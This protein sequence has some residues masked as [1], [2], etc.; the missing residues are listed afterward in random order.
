MSATGRLRAALARHN[1]PV[2]SASSAL[3][4]YLF[5]IDGLV[6]VWTAAVLL[7]SGRVTGHAWWVLLLLVALALLFE[8]GASRAARLQLRLSSDLKRDMTSVWA[9][10]GAVALPASAAVL[11][12]G[13]VLV[14]VWF[15][16]QR[17][18]RQPL[19]R[20]WFNGSTC[21]LGCLTAGLT[22]DSVAGTWGGLP[23][24]LAGALSVVCA[25]VV[26][27]SVNRLLVTVALVL[28]G[29][30]GR[31]LAGSRDDNLIEL[32]TLCLGGLVAVTAVHEPWLCL[33]VLAPMVTLQRGAL[34]RELETAAMTDSKTGLLNAVAWE[35]LA[36]REMSRADRDGKPVALL[37]IDIDRFKLVN[38][39]HGHM[40]GDVVLRGVGRCL[41]AEVREYDTVGRFGGEEFVA[42]LPEATEVEA[43]IVAERLRSRVNE[44]CVSAMVEGIEPGEDDAMA[45]SIGVACSPIDGIE[46]SEL[47][48]AADGALYGAKAGGRNRVV[49]ADRGSGDAFE[50]VTHS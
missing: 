7:R 50:R 5:L 10:A 24:A 35:Q 32:A 6:L 18:A 33:L 49:L 4:T 44:L 40:V 46:L 21:V 36:K 25:I 20:V 27:T 22:V 48:V 16:Q 47:L 1:W 30:R 39:R 13:S 26:Y 9:V 37:I 23:W 17:L 45:V 3:L 8:E 31:T 19:Y 28:V 12:L 2:A 42:V 41:D 11:L 14:Y 29:A 38:D 34:V 15:R 43:L